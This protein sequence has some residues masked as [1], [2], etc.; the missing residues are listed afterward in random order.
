MPTLRLKQFFA[1]STP[2]KGWLAIRF[3]PSG[4]GGAPESLCL[5]HIDRVADSKPVVTLCKVYPLEAPGSAALAKLGKPLHLKQYQC[6]T[7]LS[8]GHS[9][10]NHGHL[11]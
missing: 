11:A 5:A 1:K 6:T 7:L 4:S 9:I 10:T 3:L 2:K 8:S